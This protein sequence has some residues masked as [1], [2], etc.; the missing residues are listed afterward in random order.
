M[1]HLVFARAA[2]RALWLGG[3]DK[4]ILGYSVEFSERIRR[5]RLNI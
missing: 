5:L 3:F 4:I 1:R 2:L